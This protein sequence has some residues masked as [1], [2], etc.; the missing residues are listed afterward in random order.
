MKTTTNMNTVP[1]VQ[2][3]PVGEDIGRL[4]GEMEGVGSATVGRG[5][6]E[7]ESAPYPLTY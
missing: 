4:R 6:M 7:G 5:E 3:M 2:E 1:S